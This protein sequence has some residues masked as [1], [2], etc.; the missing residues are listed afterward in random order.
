MHET[1]ARAEVCTERSMRR[2]LAVWVLIPFAHVCR[3][4]VH[5]GVGQQHDQGQRL[6]GMLRCLAASLRFSEI[7]GPKPYLNPRYP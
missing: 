4:A 3:A 6:R 2:S 1:A 7:R 5:S